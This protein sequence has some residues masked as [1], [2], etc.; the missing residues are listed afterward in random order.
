M[1][2]TTEFTGEMRV[3]SPM[4]TLPDGMITLPVLTA[5]ITSSGAMP[6]DRNRSGST[7]MT[8]VRWLPPNGRR[9]GE[10]VQRRELRAHAIEREVLDFAEASR[11]ARKT[12]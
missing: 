9:R 5:R 4:F 2:E 6:Y 7:R 3:R 1:F 12:R 10:A 11:L 8:M